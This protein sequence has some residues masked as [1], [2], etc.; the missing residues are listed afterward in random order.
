M[1][2]SQDGQSAFTFGLTFSKDVDGPSFRTL[3]DEALEVTGG[4]VLKAK[5]RTKGSDQEWNI[6]VEPAS[7]GAVTIRLPQTT[8]CDASGSTC[9]ADQRPLSTAL[10][11]TVAGPV[12]FR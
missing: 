10:S 11:A 2:A 1:P 9:T 12:G 5:R 6:T 4:E 7:A 3:R 8:D